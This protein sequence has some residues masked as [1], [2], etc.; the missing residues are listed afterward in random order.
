MQGFVIGLVLILLCLGALGYTYFIWGGT[1][2][3]EKANLQGQYNELQSRDEAKSR[4][5]KDMEAQIKTARDDAEQKGR[6]LS[7]AQKRSEDLQKKMD[8]LN[9]D[10]NSL[11]REKAEIDGRYSTLRS[12]RDNLISQVKELK[13]NPVVKEK[14]V[15]KIVYR[16]KPEDE[17]ADEQK[18][19]AVQ[20]MSTDKSG[21]PSIVIENKGNEEYW[22]GV[23]R[24]KAAL[25]L[26]LDKVKKEL[27]ALQ[28]KIVDM[29]KA[30]SD[31]E[32][33]LGRVKNEK[34]EISR[35]I[36]Y[37]ED[38]ADS[39]SIELAR[40]RNDQKMSA[41]RADKIQQENMSLRTDIRQLTTTKV[42]LEK[43]IARLTDEKSLTEKKLI[44]T[45]SVIQNRI[46]E[47]WKIK[48]DIDSRFDARGLK[49]ANEVE[50]PAIVVSGG[51]APSKV[52]A[53]APAAKTSGTIV[54]VNEDNNFVII[55]MGERT[56]IKA[57]DQFRVYRNGSVIG[58][59]SVIQ[60]RQDISAAD[61][62]QKAT[63]FK[64]GDTVK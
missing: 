48:K 37:G 44:E 55:D 45:E 21:V 24:E 40:A 5:L 28:I 9:D 54:S 63:V 38:L 18:A 26:E 35:K 16:D 23:V 57:G 29:T 20:K 11:T 60:V 59:V 61:I 7:V 1:I 62:K 19:A 46:D 10:I 13:N 14:I 36:K 56:G 41:D 6:D 47:I 27:V 50:L 22:A 52:A 17:A 51:A 34:D 4:Q 8:R 2:Q 12:E 3:R 33:E 15:E 43:S 25:Q 49:S 58:A 64:P 39:L 53:Q 31:L 42:A 32:I 30:S